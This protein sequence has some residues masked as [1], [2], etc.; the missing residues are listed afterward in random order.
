[1]RL[2]P[3]CES[4]KRRT[5]HTVALIIAFLGLSCAGCAAKIPAAA[6]E[7]SR[8]VGQQIGVVQASHEMAVA[9]YYDLSRERIEDFLVRQWAPNFL[10]N[11]V[12]MDTDPDDPNSDLLSMLDSPK[13][14]D[15]G[16][17]IRLRQELREI[18]MSGD[19]VSSTVTVG[20]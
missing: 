4:R 5:P 10:A 20:L 8:M 17:V 9:Y 19:Q 1:M 13:P 15:E 18:G 12:P 2:F 11:M 3:L 6:V 14:F 16:D 7:L